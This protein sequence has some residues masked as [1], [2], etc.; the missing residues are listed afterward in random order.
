VICDRVVDAEGNRLALGGKV[1][2]SGRVLRLDR[3]SQSPVGLTLWLT[4][5]GT[6]FVRVW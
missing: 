5:T 4:L 1:G 2:G 6:P 3:V